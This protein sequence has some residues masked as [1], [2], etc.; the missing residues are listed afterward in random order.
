VHACK[1]DISPIKVLEFF[2]QKGAEDA[3]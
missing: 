3:E 1:T 2:E